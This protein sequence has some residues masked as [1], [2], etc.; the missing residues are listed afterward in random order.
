GQEE[1]RFSSNFACPICGFSMEELPPRMFSFNTPFGACPDCDGLGVEMIVDPE[2]LIPDTSK[3]VEEGAFAAWSGGTSTYYPQFLKSVCAH[4]GI[5]L[6]KPVSTFSQEQMNKLLYG[7]G[8]EKVH[9]R[10]ENDFGQ[11]KEAYVTFE[12]IIPNLER[13]YRD[14]NSEG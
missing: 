2:L 13:R 6:D 14:T 5:P 11:R 1:L 7:T 3:S 4:F 12:G 8:N 9:V 10:Y